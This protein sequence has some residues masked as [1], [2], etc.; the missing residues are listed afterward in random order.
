MYFSR[1][2]TSLVDYWVEGSPYLSSPSDYVGDVGR[3]FKFATYGDA[4]D[5]RNGMLLME[6][7]HFG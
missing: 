2:R 1:N 5:H 3:K 4:K 6:R 7:S